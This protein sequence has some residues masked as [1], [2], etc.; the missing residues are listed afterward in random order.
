MI[1]LGTYVT[2]LGRAFELVP[3]R[4]TYV[5]LREAENV[6]LNELDFVPVIWLGKVIE[7]IRGIECTLPLQPR[8]IRMYLE[9]ED[10]IQL[11]VHFQPGSSD[12]LALLTQVKANP[13]VKRAELLGESVAGYWTSQL[14][15]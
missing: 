12:F 6:T 7:K 9:S 13:Q 14:S 15:R 2:D 8:Q 3:L 4:V 10:Y 11:D 5:S 1:Y